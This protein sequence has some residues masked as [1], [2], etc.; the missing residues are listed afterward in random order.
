MIVD[1]HTHLWEQPEQWGEQTVQR[2]AAMRQEQPITV[3]SWAFDQA[4][5]PVDVAIILGFESQHLDTAISSQQIADYVARRPNQYLGFAGIDPLLPGWNDRLTEAMELGLVGVTLSPAAQACHPTHT[6]A[7]KLYERCEKQGIPLLIHPGTH[8][9]HSSIMAFS[10][11]YLFDEVGRSFPELRL[12][13]A[14]VGHPWLD[15]TLVLLS[16]HPHFY[17]DLSDISAKPW[18][19]YNLLVKAM[20]WQVTD[21]LLLGSDFPFCTPQQAIFNIYSANN[22]VKGTSLPTIPRQILSRIIEQDALACL[23]LSHKITQPVAQ[24]TADDHTEDNHQDDV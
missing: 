14:Q 18:P 10:Q 3:T 17:A 11:P 6:Q 20:Q 1:V 21:H 12:V 7:M 9:S 22:H 15:E 19:L 23:G 2:L 4:M 24:L 16:K 13:L 5:S 8:M